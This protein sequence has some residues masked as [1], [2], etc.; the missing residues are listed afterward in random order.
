MLRWAAADGL[1]G[2][3]VLGKFSR[4]FC[5]GENMGGDESQLFIACLLYK[6][7]CIVG[8]H[9]TEAERKDPGPDIEYNSNV[10]L[11][12]EIGDPFPLNVP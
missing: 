9:K 2:G 6:S 8:K 5:E 1:I 3:L 12:L 11:A 7:E 10:A 4:N